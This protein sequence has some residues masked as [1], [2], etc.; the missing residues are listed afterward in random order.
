MKTPFF[1]GATKAFLRLPIQQIE[2]RNKDIHL[3]IVSHSNKAYIP[4]KRTDRKL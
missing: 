2:E 4:L 3:P 1:G